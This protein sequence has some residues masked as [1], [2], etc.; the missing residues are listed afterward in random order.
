MTDTPH[1][2]ATTTTNPPTTAEP[3]RRRTF[4]AG[5]SAGIAAATLV[6]VTTALVVGGSGIGLTTDRMVLTIEPLTTTAATTTTEPPNPPARTGGGTSGADGG[7]TGGTAGRTIRVGYGGNGRVETTGGSSVFRFL[8]GERDTAFMSFGAATSVA[9]LPADYS[10]W[11]RLMVGTHDPAAAGRTGTVTITDTTDRFGLSACVD[12]KLETR[13]PARHDHPVGDWSLSKPNE[14]SK[15][16]EIKNLQ[17]GGNW[18]AYGAGVLD[19]SGW[20]PG[21]D[22][23]ATIQISV[24]WDDA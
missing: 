5:V 22:T 13:C 6:A 7:T 20:A 18:N 3:N 21:T 9:P 24:V 15:R 2:G 12:D 8:P 17:S 23:G 16:L 14:Y 1:S 19:L 10:G 4:A 11:F